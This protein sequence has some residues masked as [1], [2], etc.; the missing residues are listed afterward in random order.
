VAI[1]F[2]DADFR[3]GNG[4]AYTITARGAVSPAAPSPAPAPIPLP[5]ALSLALA[6]LGVLAGLGF[7]R[8]RG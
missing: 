3:G 5:A 7:A 6:G 8:R 1:D 2:F 4:L